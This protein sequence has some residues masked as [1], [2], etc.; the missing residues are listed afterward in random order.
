[1]YAALWRVLPGPVVI[2]IL[3]LLT[4]FGAVLAACYFWVFPFVNDLIPTP[5]VTVGG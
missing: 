3:L 5:D 1:M 4:V 2:R